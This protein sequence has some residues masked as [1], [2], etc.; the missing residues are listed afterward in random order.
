[1]GSYTVTALTRSRDI[2]EVEDVMAIFDRE[3]EELVDSNV[4][5]F[6]VYDYYMVGASKSEH[7]IVPPVFLAKAETLGKDD[8]FSLDR[9][10]GD[11]EKTGYIEYE[12]SNYFYAKR[13]TPATYAWTNV[14]RVRDIEFDVMRSIYLLASRDELIDHDIVC[15]EKGTRC[16]I[17][18]DENGVLSYAGSSLR[19]SSED[20]FHRYRSMFHTHAVITPD[21]KYLEPDTFTDEE[22][23]AA[24]RHDIDSIVPI[25][26]KY[27]DEYVKFLQEYPDCYAWYIICKSESI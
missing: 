17:E 2:S 14:A 16:C 21:S 10:L 13:V 20:I 8:V 19:W 18:K 22:W 12:F 9:D 26:K 24:N 4:G 6:E 3:S 27:Y 1:M 15:R 7:Y 25:K 23:D 5:D 11:I